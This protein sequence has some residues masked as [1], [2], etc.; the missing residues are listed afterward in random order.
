[1]VVTPALAELVL[2]VAPQPIEIRAV[3]GAQ[4]SERAGVIGGVV[5]TSDFDHGRAVGGGGGHAAHAFGKCAAAGKTGAVREAEGVAEFVGHDSEQVHARR[6]APAA[7]FDIAIRRVIN[8]PAVARGVGVEG[9][10]VADGSAEQVAAKVSD[11]ELHLIEARGV[12]IDARLDPALL[13]G[14]DDGAQ[15]ILLQV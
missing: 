7:I 9:D 8:E 5:A 6:A 15:L 3:V 13:R 1:M 4:P 10:R 2:G 11:L 12:G 14:R